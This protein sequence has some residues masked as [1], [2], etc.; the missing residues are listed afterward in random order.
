MI[1]EGLGVLCWSRLQ[2]ADCTRPL[3]NSSVLLPQEGK[4]QFGL[5][6]GGGRSCFPL[7]LL[8]VLNFH[9][10]SRH[11]H[12]F[13]FLK[14]LVCTYWKQLSLSCDLCALLKSTGWLLTGSSP[15]MIRG[16]WNAGFLLVLW[17]LLAGVGLSVTSLGECASGAACNKYGKFFSLQGVNDSSDVNKP[18]LRWLW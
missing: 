18:Y 1:L 5:K 16:Q 10:Y 6:R 8:Q 4:E 15:E 13:F 9:S 3:V 7:K 11:Q 12:G 2:I 14:T 17:R